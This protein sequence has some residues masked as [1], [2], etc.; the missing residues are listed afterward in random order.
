MK[1]VIIG[2]DHHKLSATIEV[3]DRHDELFATG[4]FSTDQA[5][6]AAI[7]TLRRAGPG[8]LGRCRGVGDH[9]DAGFRGDLGSGGLARLAICGRGHRDD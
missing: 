1:N 4:R 2:V 6:H 5:S 9:V 7:R 3:V 8:I